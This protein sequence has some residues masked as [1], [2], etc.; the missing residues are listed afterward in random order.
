MLA[1][2]L[3]VNVVVSAVMSPYGAPRSVLLAWQAGEYEHVT[4]DGITVE[5]AAKLLDPAVGGRFH[6]TLADV[7]A[8][9]TL[10][11]RE[12]RIVAPSSPAPVTGDP[13]DDHVLAVALEGHADYLVTGDKRLLRL[14]RHGET[15]IV[16]PR[17][18]L[19]HGHSHNVG[20][21][22]RALTE[23]AAVSEGPRCPRL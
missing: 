20:H 14:A 9:I 23:V 19:S 13:E 5:V 21:A 18:F 16:S 10:L 6:V 4:S 8:V 3:D 2:V 22:I 17:D 1:V 12:T 7:Q 11:R 15:V